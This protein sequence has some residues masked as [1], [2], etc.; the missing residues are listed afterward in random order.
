MEFPG[1]DRMRAAATPPA[2]DGPSFDELIEHLGDLVDLA[3]HAGFAA[4]AAALRAERAHFQRHR[5]AYAIRLP[6]A[7]SP[8]VAPGESRP[9]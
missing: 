9:R 3:D 4:I 2:A 5:T 6:A 1:L 7:A 8:N